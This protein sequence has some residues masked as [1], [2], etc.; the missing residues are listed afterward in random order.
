MITK[1]T[2]ITYGFNSL[3]DYFNYIYES[4][5]NGHFKQVK[6][7][8]GRL[9]A[10]QKALFNIWIYENAFINDVEK[11]FFSGLLFEGLRK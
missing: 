2:L 6:D 11:R 7:L 9:S 4:K 1:K 5:I 10:R 8:I 3:E